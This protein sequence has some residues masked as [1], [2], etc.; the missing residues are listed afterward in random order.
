VAAERTTTTAPR[1]I[2]GG[3]AALLLTA[4][5]VPIA[6]EPTTAVPPVPAA[7]LAALHR[8]VNTI[9]ATAGDAATQR[10]ALQQ[11]VL[12]ARAAEQRRCPTATGTVT[13]EPAWL[14]VRPV[15]GEDG[16]YVL[17]TLIR[18]HA[19]GRIVGTDLTALV[20]TVVGGAAR[21]TTL[22]VS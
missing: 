21:T 4:C 6:G 5:A 8:T 15:A 12:P 14:S 1:W 10:A 18:V 17:P 7:D 22:C 11:V 9:N 20:V 13:L 3:L 16:Q 2:V 19:G